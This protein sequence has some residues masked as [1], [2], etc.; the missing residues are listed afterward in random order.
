MMT[1]QIMIVKN[2]VIRM[3]DQYP[4]SPRQAIRMLKTTSASFDAVGVRGRKSFFTV[5]DPA[6]LRLYHC[7][8]LSSLPLSG[9]LEL[10]IE[11]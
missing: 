2:G 4:R 7:S 1:L 5:R 11:G 10:R 9:S 3:S 6:L 8:R